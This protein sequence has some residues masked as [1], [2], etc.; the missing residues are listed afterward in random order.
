MI[1]PAVAGLLL[2]AA[3][4]QGSTGEHAEW[5]RSLHQPTTGMSCC[6][7]ADCRPVRAA[8]QQHQDGT[9]YYAW[10][11]TRTFGPDA[12]NDWVRIP[13]DKILRQRDNP[14]GEAVLCWARGII[15][16]FVRGSEV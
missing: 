4:P 7:V 8:I 1:R 6:S 10:V 16:C 15:F 13:E 9:A 3:A 14:M 5:F 11:D 12:P 2:L